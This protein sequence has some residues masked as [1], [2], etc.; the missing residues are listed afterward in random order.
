MYGR[1]LARAADVEDAPVAPEAA[2]TVLVTGGTG[3]LGGLVAGHLVA[4]GRADGLVL[5]S[6][7]GPGAPGVAALA[8]ALAG[9]GAWVQVAA[10][11]AA[12]RDALAGLLAQVPA[13]D[14]LTGVVH[15]AGVVDDGVIG[16][17]SPAR[18]DAVMR[19][20]AD[21]AWHL[22][23][24]TRESGL[25]MFVLF[26]S[27]AATFG[28]AGQGNYAAA[29]AFLD[30]LAGYRRAAGLPA[31]ALAWGLWAGASAITGHIGEA[32]RAR[33][34][35][36]G[37]GALTAAEGLA[38]FDLALSADD[39]LMVPMHFDTAAL[40]GRA[41]EVPALLRGLVRGRLRRG[42]DTGQPDSGADLL[43]ERL[44]GASE[45]DQDFILGELI[46]VHVAAVLGYSSPGSIESGREFHEL[47]FDSLTAIELRNR[48]NA[49]TGLRLSATLVFDYPTPAALTGHIRQE[50]TRTGVSPG[51]AALKE[52]GKIEKMI[53]G[54]AA[55]DEARVNLT[56]RVKALLS[57]LEGGPG[58][59]AADD[60]LKT[61]TAESIFDLLDRE[62]GSP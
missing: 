49:A 56:M 35:R 13:D 15:T 23:E 51:A 20:K 28:G 37:V 54:I 10:C 55:D 44:A 7:S 12:D 14:P 29:N 34:A 26:S 43:R 46:A 42:A 11:D 53:Q 17:L 22:H 16:S 40:N 31:A 52:I 36:G 9:R 3:M 48:L 57:A 38:L 59:K 50:I 61:A 58:A 5:A 2:G 24:L 27:A 4:T 32:D 19:P 39:A 25:R 62:L 41:D 47:G 6:R 45:A 21:A 60:D 8:A 33:M 18:I 30:G 1:R